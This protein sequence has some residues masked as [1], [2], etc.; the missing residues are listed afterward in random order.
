MDETLTIHRVW[1][2]GELEETKYFT[3]EFLLGLQKMLD[4]DDVEDGFIMF[5]TG[6]HCDSYAD[7]S[8]DIMKEVYENGSTTS[9]EELYA[10]CMGR[11]D[12]QTCYTVYRI[13]N[14]TL[15]QEEAKESWKASCIATA[16]GMELEYE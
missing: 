7:L 6:L 4:L 5:M 12:F 11:E 14:N 13:W 2:E 15:S 8:C 1:V 9:M 16:E 3:L 10:T